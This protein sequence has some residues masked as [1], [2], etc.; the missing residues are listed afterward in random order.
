MSSQGWLIVITSQHNSKH[1]LLHYLMSLT[2]CYYPVQLRPFRLSL[3]LIF[4]IY[5]LPWWYIHPTILIIHSSCAGSNRTKAYP[6]INLARGRV[7]SP[8]RRWQMTERHRADTETDKLFHIHTYG[9]FRDPNS[10]NLHIWKPKQIWHR[11]REA[12][13]GF[14]PRT[15]LLWVLATNLLIGI[16]N[17]RMDGFKLSDSMRNKPKLFFGWHQRQQIVKF[18][19]DKSHSTQATDVTRFCVPRTAR[20]GLPTFL[21]VFS[22]DTKWVLW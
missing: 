1:V 12:P 10:P 8:H 14:E 2:V 16:E 3:L 5:I 7:T 6:S 18:M 19:C 21:C 13:L 20:S 15:F 22:D 9:P 11:H 17:E 4:F